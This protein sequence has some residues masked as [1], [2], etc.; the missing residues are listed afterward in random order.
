MAPHG[1]PV[2]MLI[3]SVVLEAISMS[4][5]SPLTDSLLFINADPDERAR[6]LGLIYGLMALAAT[7][8]PAIAGKLSTFSLSAPFWINMVMLVAGGILTVALWNETK[9]LAPAED[10]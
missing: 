6:I 8:F 5:L 3:A 2:P 9:R 1:A 10:L 4:M 7:V